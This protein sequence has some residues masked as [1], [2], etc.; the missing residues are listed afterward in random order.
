MSETMWDYPSTNHQGGIPKA[1]HIGRVVLDGT[2]ESI[3]I[4][5]KFGNH[6]IE[7][8]VRSQEGSVMG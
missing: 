3:W 4:G 2:E 1:G 5:Q 7:T 6:R 8:N